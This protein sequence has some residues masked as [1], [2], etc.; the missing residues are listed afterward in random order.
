MRAT[1]LLVYFILVSVLSIFLT[2]SVLYFLGEFFFFFYKQIPVSFNVSNF[3]LICRISIYIGG[4]VGAMM[5]I[6]VLLKRKGL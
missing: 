1:Q 4:F 2:C 6:A 3:L 5:W